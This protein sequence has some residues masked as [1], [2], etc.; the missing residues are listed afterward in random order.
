M[1]CFAVCAAMRP[2][3]PS[4]ISVVSVSAAVNCDQSMTGSGGAGSTGTGGG[5]FGDTMLSCGWS[6]SEGS[7]GSG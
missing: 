5:A 2:K 1:T 7:S 4:A 6:S 3:S